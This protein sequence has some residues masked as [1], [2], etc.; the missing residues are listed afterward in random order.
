MFIYE[1]SLA[2]CVC[3]VWASLSTWMTICLNNNELKQL[4]SMPMLFE[5]VNLLTNTCYVL[6][7]RSLLKPASCVYYDINGEPLDHPHLHVVPD[8]LCWEGLQQIIV[9]ICQV[10]LVI[11][12]VSVFLVAPFFMEDFSGRNE[13]VFTRWYNLRDKLLKTIVV[14]LEVFASHYDAGDSKIVRDPRRRNSSLYF[15]W[16]GI[17]SVGS[18]RSIYVLLF[19]PML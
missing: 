15:A 19:F 17:C 5:I 3:G 4:K 14:V 10:A 13:L 6:V 16:W 1:Q 11:Y 2:L 18:C 9:A 8:L 12:C 7:V